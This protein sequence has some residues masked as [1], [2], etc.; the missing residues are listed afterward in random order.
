M[1][2]KNGCQIQVDTSETE[3]KFIEFLNVSQQSSAFCVV[4]DP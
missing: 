2:K 1:G 4:S 3:F